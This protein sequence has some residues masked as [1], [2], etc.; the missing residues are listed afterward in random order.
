VIAVFENRLTWIYEGP[1][2][3]SNMT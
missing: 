1:S 2:N 3:R